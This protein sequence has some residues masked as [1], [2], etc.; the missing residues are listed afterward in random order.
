[1]LEVACRGT[2]RKHP[3]LNDAADVLPDSAYPATYADDTT[4]FSTLSS[5]ESSATECEKLQ[6]EKFQMG[7]NNLAQRRGATW[8]IWIQF[9]P[10]K[11][12]AMAIS[13][14]LRSTAV[15]ASALDS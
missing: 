8:K 11:S 5:A 6:C 1:M 4:L 13:P 2:P 14:H 3:W 12:Q 7:V 10:S 15:R 9:E